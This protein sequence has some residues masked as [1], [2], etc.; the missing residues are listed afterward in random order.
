MLISIFLT[1]VFSGCAS[2]G[3]PGGGEEDKTP[4]EIVSIDPPAG[5][6]GIESDQQ[7]VVTF[8]EPIEPASVHEALFISPN[9]ENPKL[10][11][12][13]NR[14]RIKLPEPIESERTL[15]FTIGTN[16]S[17][18]RKNKMENSFTAAYSTGDNIDQGTISGLVFGEKATKGMVVGA[19]IVS[20][21]LIVSPD[22]LLPDFMTQCGSDGSFSL[23]Y[24]PFGAFRV[25][26]WDDRNRDRKYDPANDKLGIPSKDIQLSDLNQGWIEL[27][28]VDFDTSELRLVYVSSPDNRHVVLRYNKT[29]PAPDLEQSNHVT[30]SDSATKLTVLD[31]WY[32]ITD[33]TRVVLFTDV[34]QSENTFELTLSTDTTIF[35]FTGSE[36]SDTTGPQVVYVYP[37]NGSRKMS[38]KPAGWIAFNEAVADSGLD[39][40]LYISYRD[41]LALSVT[42]W[43]SSN[44][45]VS[46]EADTILSHGEDFSLNIQNTGIL[47]FLRNPSS[48]SLEVVNYQTL[49]PAETGSIAGL[50]ISAGLKDVMIKASPLRGS[51]KNIELVKADPDGSFIIK[52]LRE[53]KYR[54]WA[55]EDANGNDR[56]DGGSLYPFKFSE[57]F[58]VHSDTIEVKERWESAGVEIQF[59]EYYNSGNR[60]DQE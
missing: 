26:S 40:L 17:D 56:F 23:D 11:V 25:L 27:F 28:P 3:P 41:S 10:S 36:F 29:P 57:E 14:L 8:S 46:W 16:V 35:T 7:F 31:H 22:T 6:T 60:K 5:S 21:S 58:T 34:Q 2:I 24:L 4:P 48:D 20:D 37:E 18:W 42:T 43:L 9:V 51:N 53:G 1:G 30:I 50:V 54:I 38:G 13:R 39:S 45:V 15:V 44:C 12:K 52:G 19:W 55:F 49:D 47:D 59:G 32:D 33:S